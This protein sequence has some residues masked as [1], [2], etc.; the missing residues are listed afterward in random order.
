MKQGARAS[1][2][3]LL[4]GVVNSS[5]VVF[6]LFPMMEFISTSGWTWE[7]RQ[8]EYEPAACRSVVAAG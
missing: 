8:S 4:A 1:I 7:P 5:R 6:S 2:A 3:L